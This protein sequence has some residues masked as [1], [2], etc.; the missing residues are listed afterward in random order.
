VSQ[1]STSVTAAD[2]QALKVAY[3]RE[4][5]ERHAAGLRRT[6][7]ATV[8]LLVPVLVVLDHVR[9]PD[10]FE[11]FL[12]VRVSCVT[13]LIAALVLGASAVGRRYSRHLTLAV[14]LVIT[15]MI[16][17]TMWSTG[18]LTSPYRMALIGMPLYLTLLNTWSF[19]WSIAVCGIAAAGLGAGA[20]IS[21]GPLERRV[22]VDACLAFLSTGALATAVTTMQERLRR[23]EFQSRWYTGRAERGLRRATVELETIFRAVPDVFLRLSGGGMILSHRIP[24]T[25]DLQ[26]PPGQLVGSSVKELLPPD[27]GQQFDDALERVIDT[28]ALVILDFVLPTADQ[29]EGRFYEARLLP[30]VDD[31]ILAVIRDITD[32]KRAER[33]LEAARDEALVATR[34]KSEFLANMSHEIRTPLN[35]IIGM[36]ELTLDTDLS[37][38]QREYLDVAR[39]S[40]RI[41][42][43]LLNDILDF[44]K[45][46]AGMVQLEEARFAFRAYLADLLKPLG[47]RAQQKG[48]VLDSDVAAE[49]PDPIRGDPGRL[50]QVLVNLVGNAIKFTSDGTVAVNVTAESRADEDVV[51][52]FAVADTGIGIDEDKQSVVFEVF[53]QVDG[54]TTR[55]YGGTGLGLAISAEL[56][57]AMGGCIWVDSTPGVGSTFHFTVR[58]GLDDAVAQPIDKMV[59]GRTGTC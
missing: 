3:Q 51:L 22:I 52:H 24:S 10:L 21:D 20:V 5:R 19:W 8:T 45:I 57:K 23:R 48:L 32:R 55:H 49:V 28:A 38:E 29:D 18:G 46:E 7:W 13:A 39:S 56:V 37:A 41:L 6:V 25:E 2:E 40:A 1:V 42:L 26:I 16:S 30:M 43:D 11:S 36:T 35:G 33:E 14:T 27:V 12:V 58:L 17:A 4:G 47:F 15:G 50:R 44:S 59:R 34:L 54:S 9:V 31:Q 53:T